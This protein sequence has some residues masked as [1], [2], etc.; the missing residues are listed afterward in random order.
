WLSIGYA[1]IY[2]SPFATGKPPRMHAA[3][4]RSAS[5]ALVVACYRRTWRAV[6]A[7][8]AAA[9]AAGAPLIL[10]RVV[11]ISDD[12]MT[13]PLLLAMLG[14]PVLLP[15]GLAALLPFA[16]RAELAVEDDA[17]V[18]RRRD[19]RI[20]VPVSAIVAVAP[21]A[22]PLPTPGAVLHLESGRRFAY[23]V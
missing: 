8:L 23:R 17:L 21:W 12:A 5:D 22:V 3:P 10:L 16:F 11:A 4:L 9:S 7:T 20:T 18:I 15:G 14:L 19:V 1:G 6:L 13:L 2:E